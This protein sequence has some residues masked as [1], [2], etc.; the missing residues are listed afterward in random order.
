MCDGPTSWVN[1][2]ERVARMC[3]LDFSEVI[4]GIENDSVTPGEGA[5]G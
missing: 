2:P 3:L 4:A 1:G 5:R